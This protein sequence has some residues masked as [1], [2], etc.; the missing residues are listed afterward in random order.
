MTRD[1]DAPASIR[2]G[3]ASASMKTDAMPRSVRTDA[4]PAIVVE[5]AVKQYGAL[6][7]V[8]DVSFTVELTSSST[9]DLAARRPTKSPHP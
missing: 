4:L 2:T 9:Q 6:T 1:D 8:N 7:A 5:H 3:A